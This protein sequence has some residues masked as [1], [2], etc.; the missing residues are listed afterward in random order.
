MI[1]EYLLILNTT[2]KIIFKLK[3]LKKDVFIGKTTSFYLNND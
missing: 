3:V 2:C 1:L